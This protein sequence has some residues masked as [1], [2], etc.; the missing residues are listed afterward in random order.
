MTFRR[1]VLPNMLLHGQNALLVVSTCLQ[2]FYQCM[3]YIMRTCK[4][5]NELCN[6]GFGEEEMDLIEKRLFP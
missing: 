6:S 5:G 2:N 3:L 4:I 1:N